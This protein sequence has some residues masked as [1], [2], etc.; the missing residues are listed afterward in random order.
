MPER[1]EEEVGKLLRER[2]LTIATAESTTG[3]LIGHL[4]NSVPGSSKYYK[5]SVVAYTREI[6]E[7][8]MGVP[9]DVHGR[10]GA[11]SEPTSAAMAEGVRRLMNVDVTVSETGIAGPTTEP[12]IPVGTYCIGVCS[13]KGTKARSYVFGGNREQ[14]N[15]S[16]AEAALRLQTAQSRPF[17]DKLGLAGEIILTPGHSDDSVSLILD[18]GAAFTGD[19]PPE[20]VA[21]YQGPAGLESWERIRAHGAHTIYPAHG[22]V[23]PFR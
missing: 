11:V 6:K 13:E 2:G 23:R 15:R 22:P 3:G 16:A 9:S 19:L 20:S 8:V 4:I 10:H 17:L 5:G 7:K 1:I 14:N 21:G 12:G 18:S